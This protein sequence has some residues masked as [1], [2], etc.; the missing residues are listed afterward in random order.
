MFDI[1]GLT[2]QGSLTE[3]WRDPAPVDPYLTEA[4]VR[5]MAASIQIRGSFYNPAGRA[6]AIPE[7]VRRVEEGLVN[8]PGAFVAVPP[9]LARARA[10]G[11]PIVAP[12][13]AT[14]E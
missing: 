2:D 9:R 11:V 3:F 8:Q 4:T 5:L 6:A 7:I 12:A 10:I 1:P 14:V 13:V